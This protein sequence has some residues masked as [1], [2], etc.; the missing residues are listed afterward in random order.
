VDNNWYTTLLEDH[1]ELVADGIERIT[2]GGIV[3]CDGT[4]GEV[5]LIVTV[6]GFSV[7]K[8]LWPAVYR[9]A[10]GRTLEQQWEEIGGGPRAY[11][12]LTVPNF[13]NLFMLYWPNSQVRSGSL[14]SW[15]EIWARYAARSVVA[16][17]EG[18]HRQMSVK[19]EVFVQPRPGRSF[20]QA[21]LGGECLETEELLRQ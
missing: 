7:S 9:S 6:T 4:E 3:T 15:F 10:D 14:I 18:G 8:Y 21:G 12:G 11:L 16:L 20:G 17:I 2:E 1:V 13:P 5:D 19:P